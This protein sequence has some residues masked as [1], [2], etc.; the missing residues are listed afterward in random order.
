MPSRPVRSYEE[1]RGNLSSSECRPPDVPV[2]WYSA[3]DR[4]H[5][6][7]RLDPDD[8]SLADPERRHGGELG[9]YAFDLQTGPMSR[10]S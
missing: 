2:R 7:R 3:D 6:T 5:R 9:V 10:S 4:R 1:K 8:A